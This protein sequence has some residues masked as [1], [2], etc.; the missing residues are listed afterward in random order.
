MGA[1]IPVKNHLRRNLVSLCT[2]ALEFTRLLCSEI[3]QS[4]VFCAVALYYTDNNIN[5]LLKYCAVVVEGC[6]CRIAF[7]VLY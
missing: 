6:I 1:L 4:S 5:K 3:M 7:I 2:V